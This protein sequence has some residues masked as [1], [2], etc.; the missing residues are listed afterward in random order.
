MN[1]KDLNIKLIKLLEIKPKYKLHAS[2][3]IYTKDSLEEAQRIK[4]K[5]NAFIEEVYPDF[6][7]PENHI[8][9][10]DMLLNAKIRIAYEP[11]DLSGDIRVDLDFGVYHGT[12]FNNNL[13]EATISLLTYPI[14]SYGCA[15]KTL[16][17]IGFLQDIAQNIEWRI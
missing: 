4:E 5:Y 12:S 11:N 2:F 7:L 17:D 16:N 13:V 10:Q 14:Q 3:G 6:S 15:E 1:N 8:L 9:L